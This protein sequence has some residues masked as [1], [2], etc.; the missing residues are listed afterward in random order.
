MILYLIV[1]IYLLFNSYIYD[2]LG[3][4][5]R[6]QKI[7]VLFPC[8]ILVFIAGLRYQVGVD[9][10]AYEH[11]F[12]TETKSLFEIDYFYLMNSRFMPGWTL[13]SSVCYTLG[14]YLVFQ[15]LLAAFSMASVY[16]LFSRS[17]KYISTAMLLFYITFFH[18]FTI[19]ILRE[20]LVVSLFVWSVLKLDSQK[21]QSFL[22]VLLG[23][24]IHKFAFVAV[25]AWLILKL[26]LKSNQFL[27]ISFIGV[28]LLSIIENPVAILE[29]IVSVHRL[30]DLQNYKVN[31][32]LS[33]IGYVY[34]MIKI[35]IPLF[36]IY[37]ARKHKYIL[38]FS[39]SNRVLYTLVG[40]YCSIYVLRVLSI[41]YVERVANYFYLFVI[42]LAAI[43]LISFLKRQT[44]LL[45]SFIFF[46]IVVL[47]ALYSWAPDTQPD[48]NGVTP[49][50]Y[51]YPY[52][53]VFSKSKF[54][55]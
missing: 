10:L 45:R 17:T 54:E 43:V 52:Y 3:C 14:G 18:Y 1:F 5:H 4:V 6:F 51:Y 11:F 16:A 31:V 21:Y 9:S 50:S 47:V 40:I 41:P 22:L 23:F 34:Y 37:Y 42:L 29:S 33:F 35:F 24:F 19:E 15:F 7:N 32:D 8:V 27:V 36:L 38:S 46:P 12:N 25:F 2:L 44:L 39:V 13:L 26:K 30:V 55:H 20:G 49:I 48:E 53:S 28:I